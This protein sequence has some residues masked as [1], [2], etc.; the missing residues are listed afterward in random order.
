MQKH[1][2]AVPDIGSV[3]LLMLR[4]RAVRTSA[5]H[6]G[7][8]VHAASTI[9]PHRLHHSE[10]VTM[11]PARVM[12]AVLLT[13]PYEETL[14]GMADVFLRLKAAIEQK[15][16]ASCSAQQQR[17]IDAESQRI[18]SEIRRKAG[19]LLAV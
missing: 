18:A 14:N 16:F 19:Y 6:L 12:E 4:Y 8:V 3:V 9:F 15:A 13:Y 2:R 5:A 11:L 7:R 1:F 10:C 17:L